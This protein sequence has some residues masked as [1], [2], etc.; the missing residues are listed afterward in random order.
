MHDHRELPEWLQLEL[1]ERADARR[2][3]RNRRLV[4][5]ALGCLPLAV[6]L[7]FSLR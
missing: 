2:D 4:M 7:Y 5:I 3:E 6:I 1:G